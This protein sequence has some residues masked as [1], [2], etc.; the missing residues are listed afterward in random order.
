MCSRF[1]SS[2]AMVSLEVMAAEIAKVKGE[3]TA[4]LE[5]RYTEQMALAKQALTKDFE[6]HFKDKLEEEVRKIKEQIEEKNKLDKDKKKKPNLT[7]K[8][9]YL[10]LPT[11]AG[12]LDEYDDWKF[13]WTTFL[14]DEHHIL[15]I[16]TEIEK[17]T[18]E[19]TPE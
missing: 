19:P 12:K 5:A 17:K 6:G 1:L 7:L 18:D 13:K 3:L 2:A 9:S 16:L 14:S 11:Y 4:V 10:K 8:K 15:S